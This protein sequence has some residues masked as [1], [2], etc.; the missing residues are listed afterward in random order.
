MALNVE[1][2]KRDCCKKL[3]SKNYLFIFILY[4]IIYSIYCT[5]KNTTCM[6][7]IYIGW[8]SMSQ[9]TIKLDNFCNQTW[10]KLVG[11]KHLIWIFGGFR[12]FHLPT[13][14]QSSIVSEFGQKYLIQKVIYSS[15]VFVLILWW[16]KRNLCM[17]HSSWTVNIGNHRSDA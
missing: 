17:F 12:H 6:T 8:I 15:K 4:I 1:S 7:N 16:K 3:N 11:E 5:V 14:V 13:T 10:K 2:E 9:L